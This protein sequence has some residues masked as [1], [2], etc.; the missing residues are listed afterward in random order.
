MN[1]NDADRRGMDPELMLELFD[2]KGRKSS[3]SGR[4][5]EQYDT[6][7][8]ADSPAT[9]GA[10][11]HIEDPAL[12]GAAV[13]IGR[14]LSKDP[15]LVERI[16]S[17][18]PVLVLECSS[19][20]W[21]QPVADALMRCFGSRSGES[22]G[23]QS[24][25]RPKERRDAVVIRARSGRSVSS[26]SEAGQVG[27]ALRNF[28]PLFGI[29]APDAMRLPQEFERACDAR[30]VPGHLEPSDVALVVRRIVGSL[31]SAN[32][33]SWIAAQVEPMDLRIALHPARGPDGSVERLLRV[34][35]ARCRQTAALDVPRLSE[36][37]GY[38]KAA[39]WGLA[40][41]ADLANYRCGGSWLA[42]EHG[43]LVSGVPG[44][45]KTLFAAALAKEAGVPFL[46]GSLAQWQA[47]GEAHL[48]TT[49]KAMRTFFRNAKETAPCVALIDELD[50][51]GNRSKLIDQNR[52]YGI[53]VI[54]GFLECLDSGVREGVLLV[55]ATNHPGWI[56]PAILRSGRFDRVIAIGLPSLADIACI[57]RHHLGS[58]LLEADLMAIARRGLGG[59]GADFAAWVRRARGRA[60]R[61]GRTLKEA[62]LLCEI[63][64]A[65]GETSEE[66]ERRAAFHEAGH[67]VS[68]WTFG[69]PLGDLVLRS[70][71]HGGDGLMRFRMPPVLTRGSLE[72][73]LVM[74]MSGRAA[75]I[76][77][78]GEPSAGA[79]ADLTLASTLARDMHIRWGL[80][81]A[82]AVH[83]AAGA[84]PVVDPRIE[85]TL[86]TASAKALELLIGKR[87]DLTRLAL[88]L[89]ERRSLTGWEVE[90]LLGQ[91][92]PDD[93]DGCAAA[94]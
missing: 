77:S 74:L 60:R 81:G 73:V 49:L 9:N 14:A 32:I 13:S 70:A 43:A 37:R 80:C 56:D 31:P 5:A 79:A 33:P 50:S 21:I 69:L 1:A 17:D 12:I 85:R 20:A 62:D 72:D 8:D 89:L 76:V 34:V 46:A 53:Q 82:L 27:R 58:D 30:I 44:V 10:S 29:V 42:C 51:F 3:W 83:D 54:N 48:G 7:P 90:N 24:K 86:R 71:G 59:T 23:R 93:Q 94:H 45:G 91:V 61:A 16:V 38:G 36:L 35:E 67:A 65:S 55:G 18:A 57:L 78:F 84:A 47:E 63:L 28:Q 25:D 39:E 41:A 6:G 66:E 52:H 15:E 68:A 40:A 75:E 2:R 11:H 88:A 64:E 4:D 19:E 92:G 22:R 26:E 87:S